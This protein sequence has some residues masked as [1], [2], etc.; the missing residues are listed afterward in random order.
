MAEIIIEHLP[1]AEKYHNYFFKCRACREDIIQVVHH[2]EYNAVTRCIKFKEDA[3]DWDIQIIN[4]NGTHSYICKK[5]G[6][7]LDFMI[8]ND[9]VWIKR[10]KLI[11]VEN[12]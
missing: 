1:P 2:Q 12:E 9:F 8:I 6:I 3:F 10:D 4:A 7:L 5:C 11:V